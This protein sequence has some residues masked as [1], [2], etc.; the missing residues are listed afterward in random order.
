MAFTNCVI[1]L[2]PYIKNLWN[3]DQQLKI[4]ELAVPLLKYFIFDT[5]AKLIKNLLSCHYILNWYKEY[6]WTEGWR[7]EEWEYFLKQITGLEKKL[8]TEIQ[9][10]DEFTLKNI[11]FLYFHDSKNLNVLLKPLLFYAIKEN[12]PLSV[13]KEG[14]M[15]EVISDKD[16]TPMMQIDHDLWNFYTL[17][18][19]IDIPFQLIL[20]LLVYIAQNDLE[21]KNDGI[22]DNPIITLESQFYAKLRQITEEQYHDFSKYF[23]KKENPLD[24]HQFFEKAKEARFDQL[25]L[26]LIDQICSGEIKI[27]R[28]IIESL[29]SQLIDLCDIT[30][31]EQQLEKIKTLFSNNENKG[32]YT[33]MVCEIF[34]NQQHIL[35]DNSI[36]KSDYNSLFAD[37]IITKEKLDKKKDKAKQMIQEMNEHEIELFLNNSLL[38]HEVNKVIVYLNDSNNFEE[39]NTLIDK[40]YSLSMEHILNN[41]DYFYGQDYNVPPIFSATALFVIKNYIDNGCN[42]KIIDNT[43]VIR[44]L[45]EEQN[46]PF[47]IYFY[48]FFVEQFNDEKENEKILVLINTNLEIKEMIL[49]SLNSDVPERFRTY[50][51]LDFD[52]M[53]CTFWIAPFIYFFKNLLNSII[54]EWLVKDSI[55]KLIACANHDA[56][57][58]IMSY[59]VSL[60]WFEELFSSKVTRI[61]IAEFGIENIDSLHD[62][63]SR[64]Q[65][66]RYLLHIYFIESNKDLKNKILSYLLKETKFMFASE[67][68]NIQSSEYSEIAK[69]WLKCDEDHSDK[70][71]PVF[72]IEIITSAISQSGNDI[73]YQ[74]RKHVLEY[75]LKQATIQKKLKIISELKIDITEKKLTAIEIRV[76]KQFM[77]S[78]GDTESIHSIIN[79]YLQDNDLITYEIFTINSFGCIEKSDLLLNDFIQLLFYSTDMSDDQHHPRRENLSYLAL[80]GIQQHLRKENY[81]LFEREMS[82]Q[83]TM[84]RKIN[85]HTEFY[86]GF[87]LQMEQLVYS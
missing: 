80:N 8:D 1:L 74:Y 29:L 53:N 79:K 35:K 16:I 60:D 62:K 18:K 3:K 5:H 84:L 30:L 77:A 46:K 58:T 22:S 44:Y 71:F 26:F 10:D 50:S 59:N 7:K 81:Q 72:S 64:L 47:Y 28:W 55:L 12:K 17:L 76:V 38:E 24:M 9:S 56:S 40:I 48:W 41:L 13:G 85:K 34:K 73:N 20:E 57:I 15:S 49:N 43:E 78:L 69:F 70:L 31:A 54:P 25:K 51:I 67:G 45:H 65:I 4:K 66:L 23:L 37:I 87:L 68:K 33:G 32:I 86:E 6:N 39:N 36:I 61:E 82:K 11:L 52:G 2:T 63:I 75:C 42:E 14:V 21:N 83:I 19:N 27:A